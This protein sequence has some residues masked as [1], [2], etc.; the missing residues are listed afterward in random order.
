MAQEYV[1]LRLGVAETKGVDMT[2][3]QIEAM[4]AGR[5]AC[6][7]LCRAKTRREIERCWEFRGQCLKGSRLQGAMDRN[8]ADKRKQGK[9]SVSGAGAM[10]TRGSTANG[11]D[12]RDTQPARAGR[13]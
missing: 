5:K 10:E 2:E 13:C 4:K 12:G 3:A 8:T 6:L 7:V 1:V 9:A 11:Q